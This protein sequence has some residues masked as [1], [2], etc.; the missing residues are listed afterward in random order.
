M[1]F[2]PA[3]QH[4][5]STFA[6]LSAEAI[7]IGDKEAFYL[8]AAINGAS[9]I[10]RVGGGYLAIRFGPLNVMMVSTPVAAAC[11]FAWP[12]V[13]SEAAFI[14]VLVLYGCASLRRR[15]LALTN[16]SIATGPFASLSPA[17]AAQM[18]EVH[19]TG[20]RTGTLVTVMAVG[21]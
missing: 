7:G 20:F 8:L 21:S 17:P 3:D 6:T 9:A 5:V 14:V 15:L 13:T 10:G 18:G 16:L 11:S 12:F 19:D 1:L 2:G 4:A